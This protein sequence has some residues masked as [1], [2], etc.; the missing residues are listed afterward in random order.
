MANILVVDDE[1]PVR[2]LLSDVLEKEGYTVFTAETGVEA[3]TIY[4]AN[5]IDLIITDLVMPEKG[6]IDLIMELKKQDPGVKVIAISGGGGITGRF[7][8]LP[9]A[10]LVGATEIIAKRLKKTEN[11]AT[12]FVPSFAT[13]P[14][15]QN[16]IVNP[17][18]WLGW[19]LLSV[20]GVLVLHSLVLPR[21]G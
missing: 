3:S 7:D 15:T 18:R 9:I 20:G 8:Y 2:N 17:P 5:N 4:N 1:A 11:V 6:G 13:A 10:K 16:R 14:P 19:V 12:T 21:P